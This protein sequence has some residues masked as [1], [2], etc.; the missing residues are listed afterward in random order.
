M[1]ASTYAGVEREVGEG[2]ELDQARLVRGHAVA[3]LHAG[4]DGG[5]RALER[6]EA[7]EIG[8]RGRVAHPCEELLVRDDPDWRKHGV[9]T[10]LSPQGEL[11]TVCLL[12][13]PVQELVDH[14]N[15]GVG[16]S[17]ARNSQLI[18]GTVCSTTRI[19][20]CRKH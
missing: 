19:S 5:R 9:S 12:L 20:P 4:V 15:G 18:G 14:G 8:D 2:A 7:V 3:D 11:R 6:R 10:W 16:D 13:G 17:G 1:K